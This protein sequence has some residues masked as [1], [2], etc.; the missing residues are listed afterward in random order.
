MQLLR[1]DN[2]RKANV[3]DYHLSVLKQKEEEIEKQKITI[4]ELEVAKGEQLGSLTDELIQKEAKIVELR[5]RLEKKRKEINATKEVLTT[6]EQKLSDLEKQLEKTKTELATKDQEV[7][8]LEQQLKKTI[9]QM[10]DDNAA[11]NAKQLK[12]IELTEQLDLAKAEVSNCTHVSFFVF[13]L[14]LY[15]IFNQQYMYVH[16]NQ[17]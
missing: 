8:D 2:E 6:K 7:S 9:I 13:L 16:S 11:V 5:D 17:K 15:S 14:F 3:I 10:H 12:I 1:E 4:A